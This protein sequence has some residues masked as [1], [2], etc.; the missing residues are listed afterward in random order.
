MI[1][2]F[3]ILPIKLI[4]RFTG[5]LADRKLP[6]WF[7]N[8]FLKFYIKFFQVNMEEAQYPLPHYSSVN[9]FF[10][11]P[12]KKDYRPIHSDPEIIVSPVDGVIVEYGDIIDDQALQI[13][14]LSY[15]IRELIQN[16]DLQEKFI[17]GQFI[18]LYLSPKDY[19][20]IHTALDGTVIASEYNRG[21]L[22]PVNDIGLHKVKNLFT[23]N[24]RLTT[25]F[26]TQIGHHALVKVGATNVGRIK[27]CYD[28]P[29]TKQ[30]MKNKS[31]F[32]T[33]NNISYKKGDELAR[34]EMGSTVVL[35]FEG[36][37]ITF[38]NIQSNQKL[39]MGQPFAGIKP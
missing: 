26:Q 12:I 4:S 28:I 8:W 23:V 7:L 6:K 19:H 25:F 11:R 32:K 10:T 34:F 33:I 3:K 30:D 37:K 18:T 1:I 35:L 2:L 29:W 13:K 27:T 9:D 15:S 14:G 24:E 31:L 5:Y 16:K 22:F 20:R 36:R 39:L 38:Q 17:N 21:K